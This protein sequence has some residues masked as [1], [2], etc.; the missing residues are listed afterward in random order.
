[1]RR[2]DGAGVVCDLIFCS[3]P[4][5]RERA[6]VGLAQPLEHGRVTARVGVVHAR[7]GP[8][9]ADDLSLARVLLDAQRVP[10]VRFPLPSMSTLSSGNAS[11]PAKN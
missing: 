8:E 1:M 7:Q 3:I 4:G 6:L 2:R 9:G 5:C 11:K 10:P